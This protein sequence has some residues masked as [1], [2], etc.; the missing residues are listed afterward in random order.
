MRAAALFF[1]CMFNFSFFSLVWTQELPH[2]L[3]KV[4]VPKQEEV[5]IN[6]DE[7]FQQVIGGVNQLSFDIYQQLKGKQGNLVFSPYSIAVG[8]SMVGA[9]TS[10]GTT[11]EIQKALH[12]SLNLSPLIHDLN[13]Y[14]GAN[15]TSSSKHSFL[16]VADA[17][18]LQEGIPQLPSFQ[19]SLKRNFDFT[20]QPVNFERSSQAGTTINQWISH[21]TNGKISQIFSPQGLSTNSQLM[22]TTGFYWKGEWEAPFDR[23]ATVKEPFI[24]RGHSF[25]AEMMKQS[26]AFLALMDQRFDIIEIPFRKMPDSQA[27]L[28]MTILLPKEGVELAQLENGLNAVQW[29]EWMRQL[30]SRSIEIHLPKF[31][32]EG[33]FDLDPIMKSLGV[34]RAFDPSG[35]FS[36]ISTKS[37]VYLNKAVHKTLMRIDETGSDGSIAALSVKKQILEQFE[38]IKLNRPFFFV[39]QDKETGLILCIGRIVQP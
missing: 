6:S 1:I 9:G 26:S 29:K 25:Q 2:E 36:G 15:A 13:K 12:Y 37:K 4:L 38:A 17:I 8:M 39:I 22:L 35:D 14:L 31:R 7:Y 27:Q 20:L 23:Q 10:G 16:S 28:T 3:Y 19:I 21:A 34:K 18:W 33:L 5:D 32:I 24:Y 30:E 11:V